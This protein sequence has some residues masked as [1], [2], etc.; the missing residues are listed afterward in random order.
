[1]GVIPGVGARDKDSQTQDPQGGIRQETDPHG[2]PFGGEKE[3]SDRLTQAL[4]AFSPNPARG[5]FS[6]APAS[7]HWRTS[8]NSSPLNCPGWLPAACL[9]TRRLPSGS[10]GATTGPLAPP[11]WVPAYL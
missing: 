10:P 11:G 4:H 8:A 6:G 7:I 9:T 2:R 1:M 5:H 3:A